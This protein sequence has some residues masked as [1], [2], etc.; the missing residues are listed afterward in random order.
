MLYEFPKKTSRWLNLVDLAGQPVAPNLQ[1]HGYEN[2][3][4]IRAWK[5]RMISVIAP[6]WWK[7][8]FCGTGRV[9]TGQSCLE[10]PND[11]L[12]WLFQNS[13]NMEQPHVWLAQHCRLL[14]FAVSLR[15]LNLYWGLFVPKFEFSEFLQILKC[16]RSIYQRS[17]DVRIRNQTIC[18]LYTI[19]KK[20]VR[21]KWSRGCECK[22]IVIMYGS[23]WGTISRMLCVVV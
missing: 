2:I 12:I 21:W 10:F 16:E 23:M 18:C 6:C 7:S 22:T 17:S 13:A 11:G 19:G 14:F 15:L 3:P 5:W 9:L 4:F 20:E 1:V 8:P